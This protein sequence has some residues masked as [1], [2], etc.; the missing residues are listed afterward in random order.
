LRRIAEAGGMDTWEAY[1]AS[2]YEDLRAL[3]E[4]VEGI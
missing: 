4:G 3:A 1:R 2:G